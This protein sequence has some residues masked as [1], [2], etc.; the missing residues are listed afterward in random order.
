MK[1][2]ILSSV[3]ALLTTLSF[4]QRGPLPHSWA[5]DFSEGAPTGSFYSLDESAEPDE[6]IFTISNEEMRVDIDR[7]SWHF[8][9]WSDYGGP[10]GFR[11]RP[12]IIYMKDNPIM[13][14]DIQTTNTI[15]LNI[16]LQAFGS[17]N[18]ISQSHTITGQPGY[19]H[20]VY[21]YSA[22]IATLGD[23]I[24]EFKFMFDITQGTVY[25]DNFKIGDCTNPNFMAPTLTSIPDQE[26]AKNASKTIEFGGVTDGGANAEISVE[27]LFEYDI[28]NLLLQPISVNY[29]DPDTSGSLTITPMGTDTGDIRVL[30]RVMTDSGSFEREFNVHVGPYDSNYVSDNIK[31][32]V[33]IHMYPNP[34]KDILNVTLPNNNY[35]QFVIVNAAGQEMIRQRVDSKM[36]K[37]NTSHLNSGIYFIQVYGEDQD[38]RSKFLIE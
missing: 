20:M 33:I 10:V 5:T 37:I 30:V 36:L 16:H 25:F 7:T 1:K 27:S 28:E 38:L 6:F 34:A 31:K 12:G 23:T 19:Q 18:T 8:M 3:I 17:T 21:D 35:N 24:T 32:T 22:D 29:N 15:N 13:E 26:I 9:H 11:D 4:A 2:L 14:F